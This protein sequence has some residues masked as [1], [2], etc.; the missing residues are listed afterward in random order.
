MKDQEIENRLKQLGRATQPRASMVESVM[1]RVEQVP[2]PGMD[3]I[4]GSHTASLRIY[5]AAAMLLAAA[6]CIAA[7]MF[8][9]RSGS[10]PKPRPPFVDLPQTLPADQPNELI[11][12]LIDY[13]RAIVQSP[14][15]LEAL[16][17]RRPVE[18]GG[19]EEPVV[20]AAD[21]SRSDLNLY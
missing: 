11:P 7:L 15:A 4:S 21:M 6:A 12:R 1:Q 16:L 18:S 2:A 8:V 17:Q 3:A 14:E 20:R 5:R 9:L 10:E 19:R 13:Q